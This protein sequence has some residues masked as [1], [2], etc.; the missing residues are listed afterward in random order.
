[1]CTNFLDLLRVKYQSTRADISGVIFI[2]TWDTF[3]ETFLGHLV[4]V[5]R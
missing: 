2:Y 5:Q 1:M 4:D 3:W